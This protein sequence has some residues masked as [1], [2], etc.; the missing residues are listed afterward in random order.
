MP[1]CPLCAYPEATGNP[2][3]DGARISCRTCGIYTISGSALHQL[4]L[5]DVAKWRFVLSGIARR[6]SDQD[7]CL[8][9]TTHSIDEIL[10][11]SLAPTTPFEALDNLLLYIRDH[12]PS[13]R[14][15]VPLSSLDYTVV[16]ARDQDEFGDLLHQLMALG[17]VENPGQG[18]YRLTLDGWRKSEEIHRIRPR[19]PKAFVAMWFHDDLKPAWVDGFEP[20]VKESGY[21]PI[22]IDLEPHNDRI[23]DKIIA[24]IRQ[25]GLLVADLT[26]NRQGVYFEAGFALGLGLDVIWTCRTDHLDSIHFDT[27]Q[28]NYVL[29]KDAA[30]LRAKLQARILATVPL[31]PM[32]SAT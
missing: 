3:G 21:T 31:K 29:W 14:G 11:T 17:L 24:T 6:E 22:R 32:L 28:Y 8:G 9:I 25:C 23:D 15:F 12:T 16:L 13:L 30:E 27:R 19:T 26:G 10:A 4:K 1:P 5:P 2:A 18:Q 20:A 7:R